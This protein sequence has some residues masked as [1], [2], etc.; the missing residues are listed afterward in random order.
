[1]PS[2]CSTVSVDHHEIGLPEKLSQTVDFYKKDLPHAVVF[3]TEYRMWVRKWIDCSSAESLVDT[4]K[5]CDPTFPNIHILL[6]LAFTLPITSCE[7]ERSFSQLK[8][9]KTS[10]RSTMT[11]DR[12]SG[13]AL[14]KINRTRCETLQIH[15]LVQLFQQQNPRRMKLPFILV[16]SDS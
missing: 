4:L 16:D 7:S 15:K 14:M 11:A 2:Q 8:L 10:H 6:Q 9:L 12:L 13:L 5:A 3:P 1:M